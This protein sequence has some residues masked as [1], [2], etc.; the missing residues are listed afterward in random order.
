MNHFMM[1]RGGRRSPQQPLRRY[2][3]TNALHQAI[4]RRFSVT[5]ERRLEAGTLLHN[6]AALRIE[7]G[8]TAGLD[9]GAIG[10]RASLIDE[11]RELGRSSGWV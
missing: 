11:Q 10:N 1:L 6:T 3:P 7:N 8:D 9:D 2:L 4:L 5:A